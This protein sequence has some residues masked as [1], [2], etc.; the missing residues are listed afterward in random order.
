LNRNA[1]KIYLSNL[2]HVRDG[3]Y[4]VEGVPLNIG[5]LAS[6]LRQEITP[7][8]DLRLFALPEKLEKTLSDEAP[9]ILAVSNYIW[10]ARLN[11]LFAA[12]AKS[13]NPETVT[14]M[15]GPNFPGS[16]ERRLDFLTK[17]PQVDFYI[18]DEG[19]A[20]IHA[21]LKRLLDGATLNDLKQQPPPGCV[22]LYKGKLVQGP[23]S[24]LPDPVKTK[25]PYLLGLMDEFL[26]EDFSPIVQSN[27]GCPFSCAY[28][29]SGNRKNDQVRLFP[30]ERIFQELVYI[31]ERAQNMVLNIADDNFGLFDRDREFA[32]AICNVRDRTGWPAWICVSTSKV[33]LKRVLHCIEP[34]AEML[35]LSASLQSTCELTLDAIKRKNFSFEELRVLVDFRK[36]DV[37]TLTELIVPLPE[38]TLQT[39]LRGI[40]K[41]VDAGINR[42]ACYT[43]ML[44]ND[45][46]LL[47]NPNYATYEMDIRYRVIPRDFGRYLGNNVVEI[48]SVCVATRSMEFYE[49]LIARTWH[50]VLSVFYNSGAMKE[51][52]GYLR[53]LG[54]SVSKWLMALRN[55]LENDP[56][57]AG[58]VY[59]QFKIETETELWHS[60]D[61]L[62]SF[63]SN[64]DCYAALE[65]GERGS[66]LLMKYSARA[67]QYFDKFIYL[68]I[69]VFRILVPDI[70]NKFLKD[71]EAYC[72]LARGNVLSLS[73]ETITC[74]FSHDIPGWIEAGM[75]RDIKNFRKSVELAFFHD[76]QQKRIIQPLLKRYGNNEDAQGKLLARLGF[77]NVYK[78][79]KLLHIESASGE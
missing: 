62:A 69:K 1:P 45:T 40:L 57:S 3:K 35:W 6:Y 5:C 33:N 16:A 38:E 31:G 78:R 70:D 11:A 42:V 4:S 36:S 18:P 30:M 17:L 19:E 74:W 2:I 64:D 27:R 41:S 26:K 20:P 34:I 22:S 56:F 8:L 59:R 15:G 50:F 46:S 10:N 53:A 54:V 79:V 7:S 13:L 23:T 52:I 14:I 48:E 65:S 49:Y 75:P 32:E 43:T 39:H 66:N 47:E 63:Y 12:Y 68:A 37:S 76:D 44:L 72:N 71:I 29:H 28:C 73:E 55:E 51:I 25:S 60:E 9:D 61:Q 77:D 58:E 21:L 67:M 24:P